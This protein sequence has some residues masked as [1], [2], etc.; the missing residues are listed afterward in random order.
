MSL[1]D[2]QRRRLRQLA[3]GPLP[4]NWSAICYLIALFRLYGDAPAIEVAQVIGLQTANNTTHH[5]GGFIEGTDSS[6]FRNY[7]ADPDPNNFQ[8]GHFWSFVMW[9]LDGISDTEFTAAVGHELFEDG[10]PLVSPLSQVAHGIPFAGRFR[11]MIT[12]IPMNP[13]VP[14]DVGQMNLDLLSLGLGIS[15][16][17]E[18][19]PGNSMA[20]LRLTVLAFHFGRMIRSRIL[21]NS[22]VAA[23][24]LQANISDGCTSSLSDADIAIVLGS[25]RFDPIEAQ[26]QAIEA[27]EQAQRQA[28]R[29]FDERQRESWEHRFR[30]LL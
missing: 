10:I 4:P 25:H 14:V 12:S 20:D 28:Q 30:P 6:G 9:S 17:S 13:N 21:G 1:S 8:A 18:D 29:A 15:D 23:A 26:E 22:A 16:D 7:L 11:Q 24:W 5:F 3:C 27:Q 19:H 2:E